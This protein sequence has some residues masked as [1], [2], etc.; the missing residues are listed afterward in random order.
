LIKNL[1]E[2]FMAFFI[3]M[4][5]DGKGKKDGSKNPRLCRVIHDFEPFIKVGARCCLFQ[6]FCPPRPAEQGGHAH[7]KQ[8]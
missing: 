7:H 6:A 4:Y 3:L 8:V 2:G 1:A 5:V